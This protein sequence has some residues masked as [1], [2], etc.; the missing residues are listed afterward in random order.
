MLQTL[1]MTLESSAVILL[2]MVPFV[3]HW[4]ELPHPI[5]VHGLSTW[6]LTF[7][8]CLG[9]FILH[10]ASLVRAFS[11]LSLRPNVGEDLRRGVFGSRGRTRMSVR[12]ERDMP[13][14]PA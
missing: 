12:L 8:L 3:I 9:L 5:I 7:I 1:V 2:S 11:G 14:R 10:T 4:V 6:P 13:L